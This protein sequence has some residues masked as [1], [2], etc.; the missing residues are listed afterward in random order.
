MKHSLLIP[1]VISGKAKLEKPEQCSTQCWSIIEKCFV[2]ESSLRPSFEKLHI[3]LAPIQTKSEDVDGNNMNHKDT[4]KRNHYQ[5]TGVVA[6][7]PDN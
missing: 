3:E 6:D 5:K 4:K 1:D 2:V 7:S